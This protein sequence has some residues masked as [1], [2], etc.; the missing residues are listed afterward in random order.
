[1]EDRKMIDVLIASVIG[2]LVGAFITLL[3]I[4]GIALDDLDYGDMDDEEN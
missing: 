2:G 3:V 1:M 4:G